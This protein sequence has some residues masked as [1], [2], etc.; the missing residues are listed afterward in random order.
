MALLLIISA[1]IL[2]MS[3]VLGLCIAAHAGDE[4]MSFEPELTVHKPSVSSS[5]A[6]LPSALTNG[7]ERSGERRDRVGIAA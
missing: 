5:A 4:G 1:W 6:S 3:L 2:L 7:R